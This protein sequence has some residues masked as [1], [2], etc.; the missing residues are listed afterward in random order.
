MSGFAH[1]ARAGLISK[2]RTYSLGPDALQWSEDGREGQLLY[3]DV[4]AVTLVG[5][6]RQSPATTGS[7]GR[8][9]SYKCVVASPRNKVRISSAHYKFS[10]STD[11]VATYTPFVRELLVRVAGQSPAA[12]FRYT[13]GSANVVWVSLVL[14]WLFFGIMVFGVGFVRFPGPGLAIGAA[15][16]LPLG[17]LLWWLIRR[18]NKPFAPLNPPADMVGG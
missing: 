3:A 14:Y 1:T 6:L 18:R 17:P 7:R 8:F 10:G 5:N 13:N 4:D 9:Y 12:H 15:C 11:R 2:T 16:W